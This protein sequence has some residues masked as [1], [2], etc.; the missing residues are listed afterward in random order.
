MPGLTGIHGNPSVVLG[1][2]TPIYNVSFWNL[3][4]SVHE[5]CLCCGLSG[6]WII[7]IFLVPADKLPPGF[8]QITGSPITNKVVEV[9]HSTQLMCE[10]TGDPPPKIT[11]LK[12]MLPVNTSSTPRYFIREDVRGKCQ[13]FVCLFFRLFIHK[14]LLC[15]SK[16]VHSQTF[17]FIYFLFFFLTII[18]IIIA[19]AHVFTFYIVV[20]NKRISRFFYILKIF[21]VSIPYFGN[22]MIEGHCIIKW[23]NCDI[24]VTMKL[25]THPC[26]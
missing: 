17:L 22:V 24:F 11:W 25:N 9:G 21:Y 23:I 12:N 14:G 15:Y 8:P 2:L 18:I 13:L 20:I 3:P 16:Q 5:T 4:L 7:D 6:R 10:A 1:E 19:P 26:S